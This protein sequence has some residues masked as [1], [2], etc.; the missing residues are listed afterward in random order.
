MPYEEAGMAQFFGGLAMMLAGSLFAF[1][2]AGWAA[3][4]RRLVRTG[5]RTR[6]AV[7]AYES[8]D[9]ADFAVVEFVDRSGVRRRVRLPVS[10]GPPVGETMPIIYDRE[11][12]SVALRDSFVHLW[13]LPVA[14]LGFGA[15]GA[16]FG[17]LF[18]TGVMRF[19]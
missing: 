6:A 14:G 15:M 12:P 7:V 11:D 9:E 3:R 10:G 1:V 16:A 19:E 18:W 17:I 5:V 4:S 13:L 2:G 8:G